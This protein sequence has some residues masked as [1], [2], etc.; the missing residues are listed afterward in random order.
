MEGA[1]GDRNT[2]GD[3]IA[4]AAG[5]VAARYAENPDG[6]LCLFVW[7]EQEGFMDYAEGFRVHC[8]V[9]AAGRDGEDGCWGMLGSGRR[10]WHSRKSD[11]EARRVELRQIAEDLPL[12]GERGQVLNLIESAVTAED[13]TAAMQELCAAMDAVDP[14]EGFADPRLGKGHV[15]KTA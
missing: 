5:E 14:L 3:L 13:L 2:Y 9:A 10:I 1:D 15:R 4:F 6:A 8:M 7:L 11:P 12:G